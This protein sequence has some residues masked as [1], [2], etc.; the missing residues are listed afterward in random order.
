MNRSAQT[1]AEGRSPRPAGA[2]GQGGPPPSPPAAAA[3]PAPASTRPAAAERGRTTVSRQAVERIAAR[4]VSECPDVAAPARHALGALIGQ[5]RDE[6]AVTAR[7]HGT[8][9]VSLAVRCA[10]PYPRPVARSAEA[11]RTLLM[12]RLPELTGL[13]VQRADIIVTELPARTGGR[14]VE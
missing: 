2:G 4:L 9:A 14:R 3:R 12:T 10:V 5:R 7:L 1:K 8:T 13:R 11:L 6:A